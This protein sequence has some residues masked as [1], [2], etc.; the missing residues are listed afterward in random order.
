MNHDFLSDLPALRCFV[1]AFRL[2]GRLQEPEVE[3]V[4]VDSPQPHLELG[5]SFCQ[6]WTEGWASCL[7][8]LWQPER[9]KKKLNMHSR[10]NF[11]TQHSHQIGSIWYLFCRLSGRFVNIVQNPRLIWFDTFF[12]GCGVGSCQVRSIN[13]IL[14]CW[15]FTIKDQCRKMRFRTI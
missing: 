12:R 15:L 6:P 7:S 3:A 2:V 9:D 10:F 4:P 8:E 5:A 14:F 13:S 1:W 11:S